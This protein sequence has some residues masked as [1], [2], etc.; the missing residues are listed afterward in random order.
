MTVWTTGDLSRCSFSFGSTS[1][2]V[3][4]DPAKR[5]VGALAQEVRNRTDV[6]LVPVG[7]DDA[8]DVVE[9]VPDGA[10]VREDQVDARMMLLGEQ[11]TAVDDEQ[12]AAELED[13]HV[14][15]DFAEPA[16]RRH[17]QGAGGKGRR[18]AQI[19]VNVAQGISSRVGRSR[20]AR[21]GSPRPAASVA[22]VRG[23]RTSGF[24]MTPRRAMAALAAIAPCVWPMIARTTGTSSRLSA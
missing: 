6:V 21:L 1:A 13:G 11:D 5:D 7:E 4:R 8:D 20:R 2:S 14:A 15:A 22:P 12:F 10:E 18:G 9:P 19:G 16:Q 3:S 24:G 23:K 17:T